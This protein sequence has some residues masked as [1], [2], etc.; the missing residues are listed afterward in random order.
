MIQTSYAPNV[1]VGDGTLATYAFTFP[2]LAKTDLVVLKKNLTTNVETT[3]VLGTDY[4]VADQY[5][6]VAGGGNLVLSANLTSNEQLTRKRVTAR[7]QLINLG[8]AGPLPPKTFNTQFDRQ[9]MQIQELDYELSV[10]SA[11][12]SA[13][14]EI[15]GVVTEAEAVAAD[16][17]THTTTFAT[18]QDDATYIVISV[19]LDWHTTWKVTAKTTAGF[20][21]EFGTQAPAAGGSLNYMI[22][23]V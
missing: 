1:S 5:V 6:G 22:G 23:Y 3:L 10:V 11:A 14:A 2:I 21:V 16:A 13:E 19:T 7:T 8:E 4:T 18:A 15:T 20:T 9:T 17:I 12:S